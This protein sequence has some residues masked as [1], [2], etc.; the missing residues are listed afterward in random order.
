MCACVRQRLH[1]C[2]CVSEGAKSILVS[3]HLHVS[4]SY[5]GIHIAYCSELMMEASR[6][7][8]TEYAQCAKFIPWNETIKSCN[9]QACAATQKDNIKKKK[10][11]QI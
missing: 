1:M 11:L 5:L 3:G 10:P 7:L 4:F 6:S 8:P 2:E 9:S